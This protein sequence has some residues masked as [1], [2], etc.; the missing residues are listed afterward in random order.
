MKVGIYFLEY[1]NARSGTFEPLRA[2]PPG[3]FVVLGLVASKV[4]GARRL[5]TCSSAASRRRAA[6]SGSSSSRSA[7]NAASR[8]ARPSTSACSEEMERAKLARI[9]EVARRGLGRLIAPLHEAAVGET[10]R[11]ALSALRE[12]VADLAEQ[13]DVLWPALSAASPSSCFLQLQQRPDDEEE[14]ERDDHEVDRDGHET[15]HSPRP[16]PA[17]WRQ[18]SSAASHVTSTGAMK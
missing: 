9:V 16:R 14:H 18:R 11:R 13:R 5:P 2:V 10:F 17:S 12:Q 8:P 6:T 1:D 4:A 3:K 15:D 7:R